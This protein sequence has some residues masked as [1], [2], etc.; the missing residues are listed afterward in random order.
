MTVAQPTTQSVQ[1]R[2]VDLLKN[3]KEYTTRELINALYPKK[4]RT[5]YLYN[6]IH[7]ALEKLTIAGQVKG[8]PK[9]MDRTTNRCG[10][11]A[12]RPDKIIKVWKRTEVNE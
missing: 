11:H 5:S 4:H 3:G 9:K 1:A 8:R 6:A 2:L 10:K 7:Y 12:E